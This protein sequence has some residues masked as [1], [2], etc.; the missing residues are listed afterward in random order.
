MF[1]ALSCHDII[2]NMKMK[3]MGIHVRS[4]YETILIVVSVV[5]GVAA[6]F[7]LYRSFSYNHRVD[8]NSAT[9]NERM[10]ELMT[11]KQVRNNR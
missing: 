1:P 6:L 10:Q 3:I 8:P 4:W 2:A 9:A 11:S 5:A 7:V